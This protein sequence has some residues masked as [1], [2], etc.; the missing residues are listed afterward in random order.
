MREPLVYEEVR[1]G[2]Q[3][4]TRKRK[5]T[6][7]D[8]ET[9]ARLTGDMNPIHMD[10]AFSR[11]TPFGRRIAHGLLGLSLIEGMKA[12]YGLFEGT[13]IATLSW[14]MDFKRPIFI[15]DTVH[16]RLRITRKRSTRRRDRGRLYEAVALW[17]QRGEIV[18][19]GRHTMMLRRQP[20]D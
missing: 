8:I 6:A 3:F 16:V 12:Q 9:F 19:Q 14:T 4:E 7:A 15:G 17:N 18:Q 2:D 5:I 11:K 13:A 10:A 1:V 20:T